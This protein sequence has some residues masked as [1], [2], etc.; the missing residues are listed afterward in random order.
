MDFVQRVLVVLLRRPRVPQVKSEACRPLLQKQPRAMRVKRIVCMFQRDSGVALISLGGEDHH[1]AKRRRKRHR[2]QR[3]APCTCTRTRPDSNSRTCAYGS[4][5]RK[6]S[7]MKFLLHGKRSRNEFT[8]D[9]YNMSYGYK[10]LLHIMFGFPLSKAPYSCLS[11]PCPKLHKELQCICIVLGYYPQLPGESTAAP[12]HSS[13]A[14][15][16]QCHSLL[17]F[18]SRQRQAREP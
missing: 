1:L 16:G 6:L 17:S 7:G 9:F 14:G 5:N 3:E 18:P 10:V 11:T 12:S 8:W 15:A 13:R 2:G 4:T